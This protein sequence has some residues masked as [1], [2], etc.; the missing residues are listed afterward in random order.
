MALDIIGVLLTLL[1]VAVGAW[2]LGGY[3][4]KVFA[5]ERVVLSRVLR[6]V[7]RGIYR[8]SGVDEEKEHGW[9]G[10][11]VAVLVVSVVSL[12]LTYVL[13]RLQGNLPLNPQGVP[14]VNGDL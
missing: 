11:L 4:V 6:P 3:M 1:C 12:V 10:Y 2:F 13:L 14:A 5:G 9:K 7:E 8:L